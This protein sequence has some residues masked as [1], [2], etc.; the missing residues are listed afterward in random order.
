[1]MKRMLLSLIAIVLLLATPLAAHAAA[2]EGFLVGKNGDR[3]AGRLVWKGNEKFFVYCDSGVKFSLTK[4]PM[5]VVDAPHGA[6][7]RQGHVDDAEGDVPANSPEA[8]K[9][10]AEAENA[11]RAARAKIRKVLEASGY[12]VAESDLDQDRDQE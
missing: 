11:R 10:E 1:M 5:N 8:R 7:P 3:Y 6:C 4:F 9:A 2:A 12:T